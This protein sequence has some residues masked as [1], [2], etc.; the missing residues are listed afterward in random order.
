MFKYGIPSYR[1]P[2]CKTID[3]LVRL[4]VKEED[5]FVSLQEDCQKEY[6]KFHAGVNYLH[7]KADCAAGN[8]NTLIENMIVP[9]ILLD[10]DITGFAIREPKS[11]FKRISEIKAFEDEVVSAINLANENKVS[12]IGASAN[13]NG[14]VAKGRARYSFDC[15]LQ[16]SLLVFLDNIFF[17]TAW[18]MVEDYE[19]SLRVIKNSHTLRMNQ[20]TALKPKNGTNKGGLHDRYASGELPL[21]TARLARKYPYFKPNKDYTGGRVSF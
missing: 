5:I 3:T 10:D 21:W 6:E 17:D 18:K 9:F 8:R 7:R 4:G 11:N 13:A 20:V 15:L 16:G 14:L 12:L 19:L 2:E 1:R